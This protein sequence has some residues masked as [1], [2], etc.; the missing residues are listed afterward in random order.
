VLTWDEPKRLWN[1]QERGLDFADAEAIFDG[2]VISQEDTRVAYGE[3]RI[4]I[5][6][7]LGELVV[8]MTY[9]ERGDEL[10]VI[11]LRKATKHEARYFLSQV[12]R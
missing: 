4:N 6:G 9:T 12:D 10:H 7:L 1:L 5:L 8:H 2:P 11:S 3:Q